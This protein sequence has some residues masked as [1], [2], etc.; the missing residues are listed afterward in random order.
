MFPRN[1][2]VSM[3]VCTC[4]CNQTYKIHFLFRDSSPSTGKTDEPSSS[5]SS[6]AQVS[7]DSRDI[8]SRGSRDKKRHTGHSDLNCDSTTKR[9]KRDDDA[10][11]STR[12]PHSEKSSSSRY[13]DSSLQGRSRERLWVAPK[14]R[15]K[16]VDT[17]FMGGRYYNSKVRHSWV[18][19]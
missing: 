14:L 3:H 5:K 2:D 8:L 18:I 6:V 16:I 13:E 12:D 17:K 19:M 7:S 4:S 10:S 9:R 15:V 1:V 11:K